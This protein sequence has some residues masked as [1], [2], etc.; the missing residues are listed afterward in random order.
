M[1]TAVQFAIL[2]LGAGAVYSLLAV[3]I[4]LIYRGS[5]IVNF[6]HGSVAMVSAFVFWDCHNQHGWPLAPSFAVAL[7]IAGLLGILIHLLIMRPLSGASPLV[8]VIATLAILTTLVGAAALI[9]GEEQRNVKPVLPS[10]RWTLG[11]I[12]FGSDRIY[13][14]LIA[15][16]I[17]AVVSVVYRY[18]R[19]GLAVLA[20]AEDERSASSLGWSPD[21]L[22]TVNWALGSVLAGLAGILVA[23]L[24]SLQVNS[25]G[26]VVIAA[27]A[28]ALFGG[29]SSFWMATLGGVFIG[30]VQSETVRFVKITGAAD[31]IPLLLIVV[32]LVVRGRGL[33]LRSHVLDRLPKLGIAR[34]S[35]WL[36]VLPLV[37]VTLSLTVFSTDWNNAVI[38]MM[39]GAIIMQSV[40][41]VTGFAGQISLAQYALAGCGALFASRQ[42]ANHDTPILLALLFGVAGAAVVGV[43][44]ALPALRTRGINLAVVTLGLGLAFQTTILQ[45]IDYTGGL[46]GTSVGRISV[47]GVDIDRL[48]HPDRYA[49]FV[50]CC[51]TLCTIVVANVRRGRAGRRMIAVRTNE[52]A[53]ASLGVSVFGAKLFAFSLSAGIAGLGGAL[54]AL[55]NRNV[56]FEEYSPFESINIVVLAVLGGVGYVLGSITGSFLVAGGVSALITREIGVDDNWIVLVGGLILLLQLVKAPDGIADHVSRIASMVG[57]GRRPAGPVPLVDSEPVPVTE[58]SLTIDEMSVHVGGIRAVDGASLT[59]TTGEVVGLIGPNGAGKTTLIDSVTGFT[60]MMAGRVVLNG[61]EISRRSAARRARSG[62]SRT[63]QSLEL[64]EDLS[65][66]D[67]ILAGSDSHSLLPYLSDLI[68]PQQQHLPAAAVRAIREFELEPLLDTPCSDL[69]YGQRRLVSIARAL[70]SSPSILM[71]DEPAAGLSD[72]E[73]AELR[74]VIRGLVERWNI[75]VLLVEH[76]MS[77]VMAVCD[78]VVA[79]EAGAVIAEGTPREIAANSRVRKAYLGESSTNEPDVGL[80]KASDSR[81]SSNE[82]D[83]Q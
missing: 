24:V 82:E 17:T 4:V 28:A 71:L 44:F 45:N 14:I 16:L 83:Q 32:V 22:A 40:I 41:V 79:L 29:F 69:P 81:N 30:V 68:W 80:A 57:G 15:L 73:T 64:F 59:V 60:P 42:I 76:D 34:L 2:G 7:V 62:L 11:D 39:I 43:V 70:A 74:S 33:P 20:A 78:R 23:P 35:P 51:L 61:R 75:G 55:R 26:L 27:M 46:N 3:G 47:F 56:L 1:T 54:L 18:T 38:R 66:R 58:A 25:L 50:T 72:A 10:E 21:L 36:L 65:V 53:A 9:W 37:I 13:L 63:W 12:R 31:A 77:L 5:G 48:D 52:R 8:R 49:V 67:N 6:A 19:F